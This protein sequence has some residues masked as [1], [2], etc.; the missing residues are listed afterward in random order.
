MVRWL[1][2]GLSEMGP[3]HRLTGMVQGPHA[4]NGAQTRTSRLK[5]QQADSRVGQTAKKARRGQIKAI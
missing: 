3:I 4:R 5:L 2:D 1:V